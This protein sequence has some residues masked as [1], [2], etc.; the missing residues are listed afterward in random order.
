MPGIARGTV[1][2]NVVPLQHISGLAPD[3][4]VIWALLFPTSGKR[5][6]IHYLAYSNVG[7]PVLVNF[8]LA[9]AVFPIEDILK[10]NLVTAG[11]IIM[12]DFGEFHA[13]EGAVDEALYLVYV[14]TGAVYFNVFYTEF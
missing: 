2:Q 14:G 5:L 6:R 11:S 1:H 13:I 10:F 3:G 9:N 7:A 12:K 8:Q 4:N